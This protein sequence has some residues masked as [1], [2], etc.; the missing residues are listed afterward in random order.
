MFLFSFSLDCI[1]KKS[2][3]NADKT[4]TFSKHNKNHECSIYAKAKFKIYR[5]KHDLKA[6]YC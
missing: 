2:I 6:D 1:N 3:N 4:N 5:E